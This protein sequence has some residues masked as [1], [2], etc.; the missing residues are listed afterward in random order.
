[1]ANNVATHAGSRRSE[2]RAPRPP[3]QKLD[4]MK[5]EEDPRFPGMHTVTVPTI[6]SRDSRAS[7][8]TAD[9]EGMGYKVLSKDPMLT[10]H[11]DHVIMGIPVETFLEREDERANGPDGHNTMLGTLHNQTFQS[12][13]NGPGKDVEVFFDPKQS[14]LKHGEKTSLNELSESLPGSDRGNGPDS[15]D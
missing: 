2:K 12:L 3:I 9:Y 14:G 10:G 15:E 6:N 4:P 1:M 8:P 11:S 13:P 7:S 5:A